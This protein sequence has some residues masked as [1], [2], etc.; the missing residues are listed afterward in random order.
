[1]DV[2]ALPLAFSAWKLHKTKG[3]A[4]VLCVQTNNSPPPV[5]GKLDMF[6]LAK[7]PCLIKYLTF[8]MDLHVVN[9][10]L[11]GTCCTPCYDGI[12]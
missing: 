12:D 9:T 3:R 11:L 1:M 4:V 6:L 8:R 7:K 5:F 2:S 10:V